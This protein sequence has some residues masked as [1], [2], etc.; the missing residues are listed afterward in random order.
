MSNGKQVYQAFKDHL[1]ANGIKFEP[2]DDDL[3]ISFTIHGD[4]LPQPTLVRVIEDKEVVQVLSPIPGKI[5]EEKR[6]EAAAA[7]AFVN[8]RLING[9]FEYD[10]S[11]GGICFRV[12]QSFHDTTLNDEQIRYM[13][14]VTVITT[15]EYND[16]FFMLGKG[17]M[18]LEEFVKKEKES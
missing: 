5:P 9:C 1:T 2:H 18:S 15:D 14:A 16:R 10:L 3:V 8:D 13:M 7:V 11:D 17:M 12:T 4:D 6:M